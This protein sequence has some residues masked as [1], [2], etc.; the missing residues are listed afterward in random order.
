MQIKTIL[1]VASMLLIFLG[2]AMVLPIFTSWYYNEALTPLLTTAGILLALGIVCTFI[3]KPKNEVVLTS[4]EGI[5]VVAF[6]WLSASL[7]GALPYIIV[8]DL[9]FSNAFFE[10]VSGFTTTG[11]SVIADVE[12]LP[13]GLLMWRS[14]T[15]WLG[16][17]GIIVLT[18]AILPILGMGGM[19]LY[20]AETT[21]PQKDKLRPRMHETA[22]KLWQIYFIFTVILT[23][24]L[25]F[26]GMDWFHAVAHA[27]TTLATGGFSTYNTSLIHA[28]AGI[29]WSVTL[30]MFLAGAN[31]TLYYQTIVL[32][33][34]FA[35]FENTEFKTYTAITII[36]SMLITFYLL[37][38][39][40]YA[41]LEAA[42][43]SAFFQIVSIATSTG[44]A[45]ADYLTW[46]FFSQALILF[47]MVLGASSGSTGGGVKVIRGIFMYKAA[48]K[49]ILRVL[50]PRAIYDVKY[51]SRSVAPEVLNAVLAFAIIYIGIVF[52]GGL[53]ITAFGYDFG[54]AFTASI[55]AFSN[56]GPGFGKI[57]PMFNFEFFEA[58]I[59]FLLSIIMLIGRL[60]IFTILLL[61]IP[62]F[63][64]D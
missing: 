12:S 50:H 54:T 37:C 39:D 42:L 11:A 4:R 38:S 10:S 13:R 17:M 43:R 15:Q 46:S 19:Q 62:S 21:G 41:S 2:C 23:F 25:M 14:L 29:Q 48:Y 18:L 32:G 5:A 1:F 9:S 51:Q 40:T 7:A 57:G 16:G 59:K 24:I 20:K 35:F 26:F 34:K 64:K 55:S 30:F 3:F 36:T 61:F 60:E 8:A 49:E 44:F 31:F 22:V 53:I 56:T 33:K 45:T 28:N 52:V 63:W 58:P 47:V 6:T 27:F